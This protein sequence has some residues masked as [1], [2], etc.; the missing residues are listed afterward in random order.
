MGWLFID[1]LKGRL[2]LLEQKDIV[3]KLGMLVCESPFKLNV[4]FERRRLLSIL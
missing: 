3:S 2:N 4:P 1:V